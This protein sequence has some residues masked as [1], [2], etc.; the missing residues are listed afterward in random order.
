[1][2][3]PESYTIAATL[4]PRLLGFIYFFA[5]VPFLFQIRGLI[6][7]NG[8]LPISEYLNH[9]RIHSP[10]K[11]Y[12]VIPT[13][14]WLKSSD[15]ALMALTIAG[16]AI[17]FLLMLGIYPPLCLSLLFILYLSIVSAGQEFLSFGWE[18]FL[19]EITFYTFWISLTPI[20]NPMMW[21]CLNF[22]LFRFFIQAG[23]VKL[24]SGDPTWRNLTAVGFHYQSQPLPNNWAWYIYKFPDCF[25]KASTFVMFAFELIVPFGLFLTDEIRTGVGIAFIGLQVFIWMTGNLSYLNHMTA[26]FS[27]IAFSNSSLS[28]FKESPPPLQPAHWLLESVIYGVGTLFL[29]MQVLRLWQHFQPSLP[30]SFLA[31]AK[32]LFLFCSPFHLV[33]RYGLF[34]VMTTKRY[35]II[36]E[37]SLDGIEW[38][39]YLC[40][41]K[42]SEITRRPRRI[43]P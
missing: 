9:F 22:L 18:S 6:G 42:P 24:Q 31:S 28:F 23:A 27:T 40:R 41:Y 21:I 35:E 11:R 17:S 13:L 15:K 19:L 14:F 10:R 16:T 2:W 3:H 8:I 30:S 32:R 43:S 26:V 37:G 4:L 7:Q 39:E 34:A 5:F 36:V 29:M 25:H 20:P 1:M 33:N 12:F 38:R